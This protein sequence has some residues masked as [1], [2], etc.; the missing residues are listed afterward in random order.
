M[1]KRGARRIEEQDLSA[2]ARAEGQ[3]RFLNR[4]G[5]PRQLR[6]NPPRSVLPVRRAVLDRIFRIVFGEGPSRKNRAARILMERSDVVRL[7][8]DADA[9]PIGNILNAVYLRQLGEKTVDQTRTVYGKIVN[10]L[11]SDQEFRQQLSLYH[12]NNPDMVLLDQPIG[13]LS[14]SEFISRLRDSLLSSDKTLSEPGFR[15]LSNM[16]EERRGALQAG[17]ATRRS[18]QR[19]FRAQLPE[20]VDYMEEL[21][22]VRSGRI[23]TPTGKVSIF[24]RG[25]ETAARLVGLPGDAAR[26]VA[27]VH[28][29]LQAEQLGKGLRRA[30]VSNISKR[31]K[32]GVTTGFEA[33]LTGADKR[34]I[35]ILG[36][37]L[38][39]VRRGNSGSIGDFLKKVSE[40]P[41]SAFFPNTPT[42]RIALSRAKEIASN[43]RLLNVSPES[44]S[45]EIDEKIRSARESLLRRAAN[46]AGTGSADERIARAVTGKSPE[47]LTI[48]LA[49]RKPVRSITAERPEVPPVE[50]FRP[51]ETAPPI[52]D[53]GIATPVKPSGAP[54]EDI[55]RMEAQINEI[56]DALAARDKEIARLRQTAAAS[57]EALEA[58]KKLRLAETRRLEAELKSVQSTVSSLEE[59]LREVSEAASAAAASEPLRK[60]VSALRETTNKISKEVETMARRTQKP[61]APELDTLLEKLRPKDSK[62]RSRLARTINDIFNRVPGVDKPGKGPNILLDLGGRRKPVLLS[63]DELNRLGFIEANGT[64]R[65][66]LFD[67]PVSVNQ[68]GVVTRGL[69]N[70]KGIEARD[71]GNVFEV[72]N[73]TRLGKILAEAR[74]ASRG[75]AR[76]ASRDATGTT[77]NLGI[78]GVV[79][80]KFGTA[81]DAV[82]ATTSR[83]TEDIAEALERASG[84][85]QRAAQAGQQAAQ[86]SAPA[87]A[88]ATGIAQKTVSGVPKTP[89][90]EFSELTGQ[91][92][93]LLKKGAKAGKSGLAGLLERLGLSGEKGLLGGTL[94]ELGAG[95]LAF[96]VVSSL[97]DRLAK[98]REASELQEALPS[99]AALALEDFANS[100][101]QQP[102]DRELLLRALAGNPDLMAA[103]QGAAGPSLAQRDTF[104]SGGSGPAGGNIP[105][106]LLA[107]LLGR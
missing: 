92:E 6:Y 40:D 17:S 83:A 73:P 60:E 86:A 39:S 105:P 95:L 33:Q 68:E 10:A 34:A 11:F 57:D 99:P 21:G 76:T 71:L 4:L 93:A 46:D 25:I 22:Q 41:N 98:N 70:L 61:V 53:V 42:K 14:K 64:K 30:K 59:K 87:E 94:G 82:E 48:R 29:E 36:A 28:T 18:L 66:V 81:P 84:S 43:V 19:T 65:L 47:E 35:D 77:A 80:F 3:A 8:A 5:R 58:Q 38:D 96:T 74:K 9:G 52:S 69:R 12:Q 79:R 90:G 100:Q 103:I 50:P 106:E 63:V 32:T 78:D 55:Q 27:R 24:E 75:F 31:L 13:E 88:A 89:K 15:V 101:T 91:A 1:A 45:E 16:A 23:R 67:K 85:A 107:G 2:A 102:V 51:G 37:A 26:E 72:Q 104:V 62:T 49:G 20:L 44:T 54:A 7:F 56:R 97:I